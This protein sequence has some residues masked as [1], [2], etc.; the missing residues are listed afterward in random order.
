MANSIDLEFDRDSGEY[1][2]VWEPVIIGPVRPP[3]RPWRTSGRRATS[4]WIPLSTASC[5]I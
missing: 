4:A 2:I 3:A 1:Y 5:I